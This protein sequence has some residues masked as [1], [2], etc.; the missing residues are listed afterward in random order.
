MQSLWNLR[1]FQEECKKLLDKVEEHDEDPCIV[2]AFFGII[3]AKNRGEA[4]DPTELRIAL[5]TCYGTRKNFQEVCGKSVS[6]FEKFS[7]PQNC[8]T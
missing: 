4:V 5:S 1:E 3:A 2:C 8:R 6:S 7:P